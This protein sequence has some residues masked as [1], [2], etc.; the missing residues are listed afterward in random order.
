VLSA[1]ALAGLNIHQYRQIQ[2]AK[3]KTFTESPYAA[4]PMELSVP[5]RQ[6]KIPQTASTAIVNSGKKPQAGSSKAHELIY[7]LES[8]EEELAVVQDQLATDQ[9]KNAERQKIEK[10][11][12]KKYREDPSFKK[13]M[14][15]GLDLQ[16]ADLF[17]K[18]DLSPEK[19]EMFKD[20]LFEE[21]MAQQDIF[22]DLDNP[23][24]PSAEEQEEIN[25]RFQVLNE[26][27]EARKKELLGETGYAT[28]QAYSVTEY[29]RYQVNEFLTFL[30]SDS[31]LTESQKESLIEA[32]G[33][34]VQ[35]VRAER[36]EGRSGSSSDIS[37]EQKMEETLDFQA[38]SHDA[39]LEAA[40]SILSSSQQE[41]FDGYLENRLEQQRLFLEMQALRSE[42]SDD[43]GG[44]ITTAQ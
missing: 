1:A 43:T 27:Y 14:K 10:E 3:E 25:K 5:E 34:S 32:M 9:A 37:E 16:Y 41:Q 39:Y 44:D 18:L 20:L 23:G 28:C 17:K 29:E 26:E 24:N 33:E 22:I 40:S 11:L 2:S 30:D 31:K 38:R 6:M 15:E 35:K 13:A 42:T 8:A 4:R 19:L 7:H 21:N 36:G 12:Q